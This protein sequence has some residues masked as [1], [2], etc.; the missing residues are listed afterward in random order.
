MGCLMSQSFGQKMD[1]RRNLA[2]TRPLTQQRADMLDSRTVVA[3]WLNPISMSKL[4]RALKRKD[5][6]VVLNGNEYSITHGYKFLDYA[7]IRLKRTDGIYAPFGYVSID[8]ILRFEFEVS[9]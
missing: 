8:K 6:T 9:A 3:D 4:K 1:E 7:C 5:K 2:P